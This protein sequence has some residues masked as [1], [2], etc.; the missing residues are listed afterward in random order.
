V[1]D[2]APSRWWPT[3]ALR[4]AHAALARVPAGAAVSAQDPY[5][6]HLA[7]RERVHVFPAGLDRSDHVL[8][9]TR[10]YPWRNEPALR[11]ERAGDHVVITD[12]RAGRSDRYAVA[13]EAGPHLVLRR[14]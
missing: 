1:N 9:D 2:L 12:T 3:P 6:P 11:L 14:R 10:S 5:V 7:L 8:L 13:F 4:Q